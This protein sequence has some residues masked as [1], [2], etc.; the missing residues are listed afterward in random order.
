M[1]KFMLGIETVRSDPEEDM[2]A[3]KYVRSMCRRNDGS[4][5][6]RFVRDLHPP[7]G[8][9][10]SRFTDFD[11]VQTVGVIRDVKDEFEL[12]IGSRFHR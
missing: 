3:G 9:H 6:A 11:G 1:L 12:S 2:F 4:I 10:D 8:M 7:I 5:F